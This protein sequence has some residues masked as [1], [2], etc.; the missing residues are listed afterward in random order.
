MHHAPVFTLLVKVGGFWMKLEDVTKGTL[1]Y[2]IME[3]GSLLTKK[4]QNGAYP[5]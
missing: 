1:K 4:W 3:Q 2:S 5:R